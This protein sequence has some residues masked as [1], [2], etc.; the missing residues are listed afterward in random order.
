MNYN[1]YYWKYNDRPYNF[2]F[3]NN[4]NKNINEKVLREY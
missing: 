2:L 3:G 4:V 1:L